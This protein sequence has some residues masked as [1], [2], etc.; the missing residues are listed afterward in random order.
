MKIVYIHQYFNT[1]EMSGST[2]SYEMALRM[3]KR[4]HEVHIITSDRSIGKD[5]RGWKVEN[6]DG[7]HVHWLPVPYRNADGNKRRVKSFLKFAFHATFR[8][9]KLAPDLV[10][11][12][13]TPLTVSVPGLLASWSR[14]V[15][16]VFEARDLWPELP[17]AVGALKNPVL[18]A[19]AQL[20]ER[21]TYRHA[22]AIVALSPGIASGI[23]KNLTSATPIHVIPNACD[24]D[25]FC[26]DVASAQAFRAGHPELG[27]APIV[28]YAGTLGRINKV[29]Y[30]VD[31]ARHCLDQAGDSAARF[32]VIGQGA[33]VDETMAAA[34]ALGVL[35]VNFFM[36]RAVSKAE[37]VGAYQ[38]ASIGTSIFA[39]VTE[40]E[41]NSANKFFD[42]LA[43]GTAV[44]INY[45]GWQAD[46]LKEHDLGL[47]LDRDPGKAGEAILAL[48]ARPDRLKSCAE[49]ARKLA[50][51]Q[52]DREDLAGQLV[53]VLETARQK[54]LA[55]IRR[56][57][58]QQTKQPPL[59]KSR[60]IFRGH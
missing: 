58:G 2:R 49:N 7:L 41:N 48:L 18:R 5:Q 21:Q 24:S 4:G 37:I 22:D 38:A 46:L 54:H 47:V 55:A 31:V 29:R 45:G 33:E 32:V 44:A 60:R 51:E 19:L 57:P 10:F 23:E 6:I 27:K 13:S 1:R 59:S 15:P 43:S 56:A 11:A 42:T 30:L 20:L 8:A 39:D 40:M 14:K 12:S 36:Y 35:N 16:F 50:L 9:H 28:L 3:Q 52:F 26:P 17:I 34:K 53:S 25:L